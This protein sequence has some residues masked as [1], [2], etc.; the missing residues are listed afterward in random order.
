MASRFEALIEQSDGFGASWFAQAYTGV[1]KMND[2]QLDG[3]YD[4]TAVSG[5]DVIF[6]DVGNAAEAAGTTRGLRVTYGNSKS[7]LVETIIRKYTRHPV[8]GKLTAFSVTLVPTGAP[9]EV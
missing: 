6:N 1:R 5:P 2:I 8:R 7:T 9:T 3:M 4:D